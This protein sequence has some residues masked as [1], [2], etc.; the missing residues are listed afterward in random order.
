MTNFL[1]LRAIHN[2][3]ADGSGEAGGN[4]VHTANRFE[5]GRL[6]DNVVVEEDAGELA[7]AQQ[8]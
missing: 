5:H 6:H 7:V 8:V 3:A 4:L 2:R 1:N